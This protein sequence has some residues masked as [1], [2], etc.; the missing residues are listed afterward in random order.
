MT[1]MSC[2]AHPNSEPLLAARLPC[3]PVEDK[4]N[5]DLDGG[6]CDRRKL[7]QTPLPIVSAY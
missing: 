2:P 7:N 1:V 3:C 4:S 5:H 6:P